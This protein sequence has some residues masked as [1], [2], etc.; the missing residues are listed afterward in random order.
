MEVQLQESNRN[1][2]GL[3][4]DLESMKVSLL[5]KFDTLQTIFLLF[6]SVDKFQGILS[7]SMSQEFKHYMYIV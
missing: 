5:L 7:K 3:S 4:S 6:C 2:E 1:A